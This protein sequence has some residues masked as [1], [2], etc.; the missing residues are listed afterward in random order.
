MNRKRRDCLTRS[1]ITACSLALAV[2]AFEVHGQPLRELAE[3]R[4]VL[5]GVAHSGRTTDAEYLDVMAR[6]FNLV[7]PENATKFGPIHP[8][9]DTYNF[10]TADS[11]VAYAAQHG[12]RA[13]GHVFVWH[14]QLPGWVKNGKFTPEQLSDVL[15]NHILTVAGRYR[16][17]IYAWD[18]VNEAF[19]DNGSLRDTVWY[20]QP[21]IGLKGT[22][23][24]EQAFRWARE[25][26]PKALLFYNDYSAEAVNAKSDAIYNMAKDFK[27]RGVPI[28]GIGLQA[29]FT[30]A[31]IGKF[32][33]MGDNIKRITALGLQVQI[34]ELD[35]RLRLDASG[36]PSE[37]DLAAQANVYGGLAAICLKY[38]LCTAI[39]IWGFTDKYSWIPRA[40]PGFGAALP[41]DAAYQP[42]P[43][44]NALRDALK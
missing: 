11:I 36:K 16:D 41:F 7:E 1:R 17:K 44:Y 13:R 21:G 28:D 37:A 43:A 18:V 4:G 32:A 14:N 42:K 35:V 10:A 22:A 3:K 20:N 24:I 33:S 31:S 27:A 26:D 23:Y 25:A 8:A 9:E 2:F 6:E 12:M 15:H 30:T 38:P 39:Q 5:I 29:H 34:T 40:N 19:L